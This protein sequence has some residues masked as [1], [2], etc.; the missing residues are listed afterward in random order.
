[1][2]IVSLARASG[3]ISGAGELRQLDLRGTNADWSVQR[4]AGGV[5]G[6]GLRPLPSH[7]GSGFSSRS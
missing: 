5:L 1:M 4:G 2:V 3:M 6:L 7:S